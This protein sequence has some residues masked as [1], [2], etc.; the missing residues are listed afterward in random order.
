MMNPRKGTETACRCECVVRQV[1]DVGMV[2]VVSYNRKVV[3]YLSI[4]YVSDPEAKIAFIENR[5][6]ANYADGVQQSFPVEGVESITLLTKVQISTK[7]MEQCLKRGIPVAFF[8]KDGHY[9][10]RLVSTGH[11]NAA[12][13]RRQSTLY[14]TPFSLELSRRLIAAKIKNQLVVMR[15]Y[16]RSKEADL[17]KLEEKIYSFY[18]KVSH[19]DTIEEIMGYEGQC[20]KLYFQGLSLCIDTEFAFKGRSRRPPRN[21]FNSLI[22]LGYSVL[23]NEI[24]NEIETKGLNPYFGFMHRDAENHPTLASD[25]LEEWRAVLIDS[26]AMSLIN[27]HEMSWEHFFMGDDEHPGCYLTK[28]GLRIFLKKLEKKLQVRAKYLPYVTNQVTF[29]RAIA[30][31]LGRLTEAIKEGEAGIY[32]P[33]TIR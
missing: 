3:F 11:V 14:D 1:F 2:K 32:E 7:C 33:I 15:R 25:M 4:L 17:Q 26:M 30:L 23:M 10:G 5:V 20:A 8:S 6:V 31:Q 9:F 24:Y 27:G 22:S 18:K 16:A 29:R 28:D 19:L 12:L 13:Q 21:P